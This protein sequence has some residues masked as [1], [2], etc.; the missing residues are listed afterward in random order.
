MQRYGFFRVIYMEIVTFEYGRF[1][2]NSLFS[3]KYFC[4][5]AVE[6]SKRKAYD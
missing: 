2:I 3:S 4:N 1:F 6:M 5:F